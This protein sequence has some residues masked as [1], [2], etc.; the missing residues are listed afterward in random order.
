MKISA[1]KIFKKSILFTV[2]FL[3]ICLSLTIINTPYTI[4]F[5]EDVIEYEIT[6][7][8]GG[9]TV[10]KT[11]NSVITDSDNIV[12]FE[13]VITWIT[14]DVDFSAQSNIVLDGNLRISV[15]DGDIED[16]DIGL[17]M[18]NAHYILKDT[19]TFY[20]GD[21]TSEL[22]RKGLIFNGGSVV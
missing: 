3:V 4:S 22:P 1:L 9:F 16:P 7:W 17:V 14:A 6:D 8:F 20:L 5:A 15:A 18:P 2:C 12:P 19:I 13:D 21:G 10:T 11:V